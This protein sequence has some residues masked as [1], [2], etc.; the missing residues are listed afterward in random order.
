MGNVIF[1]MSIMVPNAFLGVVQNIYYH[2]EELVQW[3]G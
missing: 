1:L 2:I 3:L